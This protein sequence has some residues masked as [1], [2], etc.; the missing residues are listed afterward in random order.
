MTSIHFVGIKVI[1]RS[2]MRV[3]RQCNISSLTNP[4]AWFEDDLCTKCGMQMLNN[5]LE[6]ISQDIDYLEMHD[7]L[8]DCDKE[9]LSRLWHERNILMNQIQNNGGAIY[10]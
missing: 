6:E 1:N 4:T 9:R 3:C 5:R 8:Y 2:V 7:D 10:E